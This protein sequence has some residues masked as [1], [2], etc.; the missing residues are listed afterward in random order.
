MPVFSLAQLGWKST[1]AQQLDPAESRDCLPARVAAVHKSHLTL[2]S[3]EGEL[4]LPAALFTRLGACTVGDWV[5]LDRSRE[6]PLRRLQRCG[7]LQ[8]KAPGEKAEVQLMAANV[9]LLLIVS[10]CNQ[11]FKAARLERYLALAYEA[12]I[13]PVVVLT[14]ADLAED[15]ENYRREAQRL[16]A[17]LLVETINALDRETLGGLLELCG[18]GQTLV[19]AGSSG[20]GKST[21]AGTLGVAGLDTAPIRERDSSGRH[22]T[23]SRS[24]HLLDSGA[25]LIDSPGIR[26]LQLP[27]CEQGLELLFEDIR[28]A[29]PC[30]FVDCSHT[31]EPGCAVLEAVRHGRL[32]ER[33]VQSY[34]KLLREQRYNS[35]TL[36]EKHERARK[37]GKLYKSVQRQR[38]KERDPWQ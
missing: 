12:G 13:L 38:R 4:P 8:R 2:L 7:L 14:K 31:R 23:T 35:E 5:L 26:E 37:Q 30:R 19:M 3:E 6:R 36:A 16:R 22:T 20:V 15:A 24:L 25:V 28:E 18:P 11:E 34:R 32:D 21:L 27:A 33:R 17:G 10:S 9:D 1:F 29:G